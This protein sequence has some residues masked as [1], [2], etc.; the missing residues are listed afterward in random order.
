MILNPGQTTELN[1]TDPVEPTPEPTA[2]GEAPPPATP[3]SDPIPADDDRELRDQVSQIRAFQEV[4]GADLVW[5]LECLQRL[6][7]KRKV[8]K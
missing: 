6:G 5:A 8:A 1:M 7:F 3:E 4:Q 2:D